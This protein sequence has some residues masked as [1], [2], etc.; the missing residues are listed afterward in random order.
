MDEDFFITIDRLR[1]QFNIEDNGL[2]IPKEASEKVFSIFQKL[3]A[4]P[5]S[6]GVGM[7]IV[8]K[9]IESYGGE[10]WYESEVGKGTIFSF[11][12]PLKLSV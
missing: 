6:N 4:K 8:K 11:N 5:E 7:S 1:N 12:L 10:I 3:H 9:I 2:G